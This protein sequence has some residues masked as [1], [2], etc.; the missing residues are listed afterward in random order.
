M[1]LRMEQLESLRDIICEEEQTTRIAI[2]A[3]KR[4]E[5]WVLLL[6]SRLITVDGGRLFGAYGPM[7][8]AVVTGSWND[9]IPY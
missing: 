7:E 1:V 6:G 8:H 9:L 5:V 4:V 2:E 3:T